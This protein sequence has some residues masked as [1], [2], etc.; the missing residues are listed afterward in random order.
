[1]VLVLGR[2]KSP[3]RFSIQ[4]ADHPFHKIHYTYNSFV[5]DFFRGI[6]GLVVVRV[7]A[8]EEVQDRDVLKVKA[9]VVTGAYAAFT[10]HQYEA[11]FIARL[12]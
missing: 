6:A 3:F 8:R 5:V 4:F 2:G 12:Q 7:L 11:V 9:R 10:R 1:M